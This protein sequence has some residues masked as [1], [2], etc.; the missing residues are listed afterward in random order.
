[1][2]RV[3]RLEGGGRG[4]GWGR[5]GEYGAGT[6]QHTCAIY[7]CHFTPSTTSHGGALVAKVCGQSNAQ[8]RTCLPV[9]TS[10]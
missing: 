9:V 10:K 1:M 8:A 4:G 2:G 5:E 6:H 3:W 7:P